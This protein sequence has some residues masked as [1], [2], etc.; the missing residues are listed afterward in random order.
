[1][2]YDYD[3]YGFPSAGGGGN[4]PRYRYTGQVFLPEAGLYDYKARAYS[5]GLGRFLQTDPAGYA[6]DLNLYAY[7]GNDPVNQT[8]PSGMATE[9]SQPMTEKTY[10]V[11]D[12]C[13]T[14]YNPD[15]GDLTTGP[16]SRAIATTISAAAAPSLPRLL[17]RRRI[18]LPRAEARGTRRRRRL[19]RFRNS[20]VKPA[21]RGWW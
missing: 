4:A 3:E 10:C 11:A 19:A 14:D 12:R 5:L 8:D 9:A 6:S 2:T 1:M 16:C 20:A 7:A 13:W 17:S 21:W 18:H 15:T